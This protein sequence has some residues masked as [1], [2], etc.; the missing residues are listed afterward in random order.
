MTISLLTYIT[1]MENN[2]VKSVVDSGDV[3][4]TVSERL[5]TKLSLIIEKHIG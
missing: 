4:R 2:G 3:I 5:L 1:I